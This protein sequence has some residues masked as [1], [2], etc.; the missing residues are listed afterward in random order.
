VSRLFFRAASP[1]GLA[2]ALAASALAAES[3]LPRRELAPLEQALSEAVGQVSYPASVPM[4][5]SAETC[6]GYRLPG[7]G[8]LFV[9]SPRLVPQRIAMK[10]QNALESDTARVDRELTRSISNLEENLKAATADKDKQ[11]L[12][13]AIA[14][15]KDQQ[16]QV[17]QRAAAERQLERE[18]QVYEAEVAAMHQQALQAQ[19]E[20]EESMKQMLDRLPRGPAAVSEARS[21]AMSSHRVPPWVNWVRTPAEDARTP[22]QVITEVRRALTNVLEQHG[23]E[24]E[25]LEPDE[26]VAV[27]VDFVSSVGG[28]GPAAPAR[29][30][31]VRAPK[32]VLDALR[33]G[34]LPVE[35]ARKQF[36][37]A[38]Y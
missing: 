33:A 19:R 18:I 27:A 24:L 29:T 13:N 3:K 17:R 15:M 37:V 38:E 7:F 16:R 34:K 25:S 11:E 36:Q 30:L 26:V 22:E 35:E 5:G 21:V 12:T 20:A 9:I 31:V 32:S 2:V 10:T 6:R 28:D 14:R 8:A 23:A 1:A 4:M